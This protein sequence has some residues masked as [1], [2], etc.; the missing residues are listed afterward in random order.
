[1]RVRLLGTA[2]GGGFPQWNCGCRNCRAARAGD[3]RATPRAQTCV[4]LTADDRRW[5]LVGASPDIRAQ[6]ES[7]PPLGVGERVRGG[8]LEGVL[9]TCADLDHVLGLFLLREGGPLCVHAASAVRRSLCEGLA[10]DDVL[11]RYCGLVWRDPPTD[12]GPLLDAD[13]RPS[14]LRYEAFATPG[15]P[16]RYREGRA[17]SEPG[18]CVGYRF[19]D[20]RTGGSLVVAPGIA[21][22]DDRIAERLA[23]CD[24][25]LIDGTFWSEHEMRDAGVGGA[26]ASAMGHLPIGGPGGS[27][28]RISGLPRGR[29]IY[30]HVNNTNPILLDDSPERRLVEAAG[31]EVGR[32]GMEWL[33]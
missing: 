27:L 22:I 13:G 11:G 16:P 30:I 23:E 26:S 9:L 17:P 20:E 6:V 18:D 29:T 33:L 32:D 24:V 15:K 3:P 19:L 28:D 31:A 5:F 8:A 1:M 2:A 10:I 7:F 25:R 4:A 14:G 21:A 12:P